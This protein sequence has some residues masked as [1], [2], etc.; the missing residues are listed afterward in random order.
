MKVLTPLPVTI[1]LPL[2]A[3]AEFE[4]F[5]TLP[6]LQNAGSLTTQQYINALYVIAIAAASILAVFK[7][8]WAGVQYMLSDVVTSKQKAKGDI[9]GALLGLLI[10]L[11]AVTILNTINPNLTQINFLRNAAP[12]NPVQGS[13]TTPEENIV[14]VVETE[15]DCGEELRS[16]GATDESGMNN[17]T[18]ID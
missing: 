10:I 4:P 9:Q 2:L 13:N 18:C 5:Q 8:M 14:N 17:C 1:C 12:V 15:I 16:C 6:G 7:L 11:A 3:H